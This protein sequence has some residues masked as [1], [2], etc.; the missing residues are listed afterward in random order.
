MAGMRR[1]LLAA[2]VT[3]LLIPACAGGTGRPMSRYYDPSGLFAIDLPA[4]DVVSP[5][6]S[7]TG[8]AAGQP[9]LLGGVQAAPQPPESGTTFGVT[10]TQ[11]D[12]TLYFVFVYDAPQFSSTSD[13]VAFVSTI[14]GVDLRVERPATIGGRAGRLVVTDHDNESGPFSVASGFLLEG[15][16]AYWI[17][18]L[19][20]QGDWDREEEDFTRILESFRTQVP[21]GINAFP[22]QVA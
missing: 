2:G 11:Q 15:N 17:A 1:A 9:V 5:V 6:P 12:Q 19:F 13:L 7:E 20:P 18:A 8:D 4:E 3:A 22:V 16:V 21:A 10:A 14:G